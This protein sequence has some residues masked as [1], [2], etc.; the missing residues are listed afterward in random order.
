MSDTSKKLELKLGALKSS[1]EKRIEKQLKE[2]LANIDDTISKFI[3]DNVAQMVMASLGYRNTWG[4]WEVD[5]S[6]GRTTP[7]ASHISAKA[8]EHATRMFDLFIT[9]DLGIFIDDEMFR[10]IREFTREEFITRVKSEISYKM[11]D[12]A[13]LEAEKLAQRL[14]NELSAEV[15]AQLDTADK[16]L[17]GGGE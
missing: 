3:D 4:K 8:R 9:S 14:V 16:E 10:E 2:K 7:A 1:L 11:R 13:L 17:I 12:R 15:C 5:T 6:N